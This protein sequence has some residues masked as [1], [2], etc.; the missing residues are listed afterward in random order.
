MKETIARRLDTV[1]DQICQA[2][3]QAHR[4]DDVVLV[5]VTKTVDVAGILEAYDAGQRF[6]GENR[7]QEARRKIETAG[8][9]MDEASWHLIGNL[10]SNKVKSAVESFDLIQSVD[11]MPLAE[12]L[13]L[14]A[15]AQRVHMPVL[16]EVN[17]AR[18]P[19]K[20]GFAVDAL[21]VAM[22]RL[23]AL[24]NLQLSGLMTV[25][26]LVADAESVR[27]VFQKLRHLRE[28]LVATRELPAFRH[29]SMGMSNDFVVAIHEGATIV[30][31]GRSIF[32]ERR[33][34]G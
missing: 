22:D 14:Q 6:F 26:P 20:S 24:E 5:A 19:T 31:I 32:G 1:R 16:L 28:R 2:T 4:A 3:E 21:A 34:P 29:L 9:R 23:L 11:S 33:P 25:A 12:R 13:N 7:V 17:V 18:E 15:Q 8:T 30:R 10:Q 27:G